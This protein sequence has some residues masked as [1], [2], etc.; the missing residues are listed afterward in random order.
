M[1]GIDRG[2][3]RAAWTVALVALLLCL[4][5]LVR[6]TLFVFVLAVLFAYLLTPLVDL[7]DRFLPTG[8]RTPALAL[9]YVL[10]VGAVVFGGIQI[11]VAD[12]RPDQAVGRRSSRR[13]REMAAGEA[14]PRP[15]PWVAFEVQLIDKAQLEISE[16]A[17]DLISALPQA[18]ARFVQWPAA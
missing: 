7:L 12:F 3:A 2:A 8:T 13:Y 1:L 16:Q 15:P 14:R 11:G 10:F 4:I 5:Y 18:G 9:A 17:N 6:T